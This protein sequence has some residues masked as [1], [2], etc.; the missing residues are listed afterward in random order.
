M[1]ALLETVK[2]LTGS[3]R[4]NER[5]CS[6]EHQMKRGEH[7]RTTRQLNTSIIPQLVKDHFSKPL[8]LSCRLFLPRTH[9]RQRYKLT[10]RLHNVS[11]RNRGA[12]RELHAAAKLL[13][14]NGSWKSAVSWQAS[15]MCH[16]LRQR[17]SL[18]C[19]PI[20]LLLPRFQRTI[21]VGTSV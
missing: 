2:H 10:S 14:D 7:Y 19:S 17:A 1:G 20:G 18:H 16:A 5:H 9:T 13:Q 12:T 6:L 11:E 8:H 4:I 21:L 3:W 15:G